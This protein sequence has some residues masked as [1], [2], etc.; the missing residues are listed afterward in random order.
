MFLTC[1]SRFTVRG[2]D[3]FLILIWT[4]IAIGVGFIIWEL[5]RARRR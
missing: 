1:Y 5:W 4:L 3:L 2:Q